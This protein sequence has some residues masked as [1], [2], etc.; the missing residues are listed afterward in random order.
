MPSEEVTQVL[1]ERRVGEVSRLL[2]VASGVLNISDVTALHKQHF[3][4][5]TKARFTLEIQPDVASA[6]DFAVCA[7][8]SLFVGNA[9]SAFSYLLREG[10]LV[11]GEAERAGYYNL[12]ADHELGDITRREA[13]RWNVLPLGVRAG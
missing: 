2:Y 11:R 4:V 9:Y 13:V 6:V 7:T 3:V 12:D 1:E 5:M 10:A 8:A